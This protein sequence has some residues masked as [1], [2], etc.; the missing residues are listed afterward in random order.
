MPKQKCTTGACPV[1]KAAKPKKKIT[2][3][4]E[5]ATTTKT[6]RKRSNLVGKTCLERSNM[7]G[8]CECLPG[9]KSKCGLPQ[10]PGTP[11]MGGKSGKVPGVL[12]GGRC[13][14][15]KSINTRLIEE[16]RRF[17]GARDCEVKGVKGIKFVGGKVCWRSGL[18]RAPQVKYAVN[19]INTVKGA[20]YDKI[21]SIIKKHDEPAAAPR[22]GVPMD[23]D[24][25]TITYESSEEEDVVTAH[26]RAMPAMPVVPIAAAKPLPARPTTLHPL[27]L[28]F[29]PNARLVS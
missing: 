15:R 7:A 11:C 24:E 8:Y 10:Y 6:G 13:I 21:R 9:S 26:A 3:K 29:A 18:K 14:S 16:K 4:E 5:T 25:R 12:I 23:V 27:G 19:W 2:K 22:V 17:Q 1:K 20:K 28:K